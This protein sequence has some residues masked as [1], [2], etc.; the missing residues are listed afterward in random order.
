MSQ[1]KSNDSEALDHLHVVILAGGSGER[2]WPLSRDV[3]PKHLLRFFD[4]EPLI[5]KTVRRLEGLVPFERIWILVQEA[6]LEATAQ[7]LPQL[8]R[9][10][11]IAE[12]ARRD[13]GPAAALAAALVRA[14]DPHGIVALLPADHLIV[15]AAA[16]RTQLAQAA[17]AA[18]AQAA[19]VTFGIL[20]THPAD[21]F[22]YLKIAGPAAAS[23]FFQVERFVEK[24]DIKTATTYLKE[25]GYSWNSG[26]FVWKTETFLSEAKRLQPELAAFVEKYPAA[27]T[28]AEAYVRERFSAL[29]K[30]SFD[31]A[32]LEKAANVLM[33]PAA[34]DWDDVGSWTAVA[35]HA[36]CDAN[37]NAILS[38]KNNTVALHEAQDNV[39][40]NEC[41][42]KPIALCGV[43]NLVVVQTADALLICHKEAA[44]KIKAL[45]GSLPEELR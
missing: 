42:D 39:V 5:A 36:A 26:M 10:Q 28:A 13:T 35:R 41:P 34:F 15:N 24:P 2:F 27:P 40:V 43:N 29:P 6:Q 16:L 21:G 12:P 25:G 31:Y 1:K 7:A 38:S 37:G 20:P 33:L 4:A 14:R 11:F 17:K 32:I 44:Q 30:I 19:F 23:D 18:A 8:P 9:C 45:L 3:T 22:G